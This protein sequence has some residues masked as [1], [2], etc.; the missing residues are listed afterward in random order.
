MTVC[1][2]MLYAQPSGTK[3]MFAAWPDTLP[4]GS[5]RATQSHF[6]YDMQF[7]WAAHFVSIPLPSAK[8][9]FRTCALLARMQT[10]P[11]IVR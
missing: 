3:V 11:T 8:S 2:L 5:C 4:P 1:D 9:T 7:L 10:A 6:E